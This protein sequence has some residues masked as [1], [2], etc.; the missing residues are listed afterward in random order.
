[1]KT[2]VLSMEASNFLVKPPSEPIYSSLNRDEKAVLLV[3]VN[4]LF[5]TLLC[6]KFYPILIPC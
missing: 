1:M 6:E 4:P 5:F 2:L 3:N